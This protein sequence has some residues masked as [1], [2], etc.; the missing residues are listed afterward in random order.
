MDF[1]LTIQ[2]LENKLYALH[3]NAIKIYRVIND[4]KSLNDENIKTDENLLRNKIPQNETLVFNKTSTIAKKIELALNHFNRPVKINE[5]R[6]FIKQ[7]E[8]GFNKGL[9]T[10][11]RV[12]RDKN[13]IEDYK[14]SESNKEVYYGYKVWFKGKNELKEGFEPKSL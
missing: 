13:I 6:D 14:G 4:L 5:I 11:L 9:N 7:Y 2:D 8:P 3:P 10:A 12:M 1:T